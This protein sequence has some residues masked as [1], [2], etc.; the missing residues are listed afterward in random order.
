MSANKEKELSE[1]FSSSLELDN[2][3][4]R[5]GN[6]NIQAQRE[7]IGEVFF[8]NGTNASRFHEPKQIKIKK[9]RPIS[10][11]EQENLITNKK[12]TALYKFFDENPHISLSNFQLS[13]KLLANYFDDPTK[14]ID[15]I[16]KLKEY[17]PQGF[18]AHHKFGLLKIDCVYRGNYIK[19]S[20][21]RSKLKDLE[22]HISI[23]LTNNKPES[24][25]VFSQWNWK[26]KK[27]QLIRSVDITN[28]SQGS[29]LSSIEFDAKI[30]QA[31]N[32]GGIH[33]T[34]FLKSL[35]CAER[36]YRKLGAFV[37]SVN[38]KSLLNIFDKPL[39]NNASIKTDNQSSS[40]LSF[41]TNTS[42]KVDIKISKYSTSL[43]I[44]H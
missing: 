1:T 3:F 30:W 20:L 4:L 44:E 7:D 12:L 26:N 32:S 6:Q 28:R 31:Y 10:R 8:N 39:I 17:L 42:Q 38:K 23:N 13:Q 35:D 24:F 11:E 15:R 9:P 18:E 5:P 19:I 16:V 2:V 36:N 34:H 40:M 41:R 14:F 29:S 33:R 27:Y 22:Q 43:T 21:A 25:L 37:N